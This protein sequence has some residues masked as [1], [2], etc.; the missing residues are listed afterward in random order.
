MS[1]GPVDPADAES[2]AQEDPVRL[3]IE[4]TLDLHS[5]RPEEVESVIGEYLNEALL[6]GFREVRIIHGRGIGVQREI[7]RSV[8]ARTPWVTSF[9]DARPESGGWGATIA[10]IARGTIT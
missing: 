7:V 9:Q 4:P 3:P 1:E 2:P 8:L 5:F 6:A 10:W